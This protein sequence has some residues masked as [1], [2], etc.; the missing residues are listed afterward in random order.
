MA[1]AEANLALPGAITDHALSWWRPFSQ[2]EWDAGEK[3][4][5]FPNGAR[6]TFGYLATAN[7]RYRYQGSAYQYIGFDELT[8]FDEDDYLH[9]FS[10]PRRTA[11]RSKQVKAPA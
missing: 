9:L 6:I 5:T 2:I 7:D 8:Q 11:G 10:R 4:F 1:V 3:T